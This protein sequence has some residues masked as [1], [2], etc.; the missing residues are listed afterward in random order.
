MDLHT[1][2]IEAPV[3]L[4]ATETNQGLLLVV[5]WIDADDTRAYVATWQG[6]DWES[7]W[8]AP[9]AASS[10][11]SIAHDMT[12]GGQGDHL[13]VAFED[14]RAG[15]EAIYYSESN[16]GGMTFSTEVPLQ[17]QGSIFE[18]AGGDPSVA[19]YD[20]TVY[21]AW[22]AQLKVNAARASVGLDNWTKV[23]GPEFGLFVR[24]SA[25]ESAVGLTWEHF[26]GAMDDDSV[27]RVGLALTLDDFEN[28]TG[29]F[30]LDG[31]DEQYGLIRSTVTVSGA[32]V[33][34]VWVDTT[35]DTSQTLVH[36]SGIIQ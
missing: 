9:G 26:E 28:V 29:P 20:G 11:S 6:G 3:T 21:I 1:G 19:E 15:E 13:L 27:K 12:I 23:Y 4:H 22:Q 34:L 16:D 33:D 24:V 35:G 18:V 10:V 17:L 5:G 14:T 31:S 32:N 30:A 8:S 7:G 2:N 25:G 36:R